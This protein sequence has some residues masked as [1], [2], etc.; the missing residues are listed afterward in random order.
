MLVHEYFT[1]VEYAELSPRALKALVDVYTQFRGNNNGDLQA[2]W[3]LMSKRGW[4]SKDQL[5]KAICE[6]LER[7]WLLVTRQGG[8]QGGRHLPRLYA[9]TW[10][11][12]DYC[13][14]K[15]DVSPN[16]VPAHAWKRPA[17]TTPALH[18]PRTTGQP[19]PQHGSVPAPG[20]ADRPATRV[21]QAPI[22]TCD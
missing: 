10:L 3:S 13:G 15:L 5:G 17:N 22:P 1:S 8:F 20:I 4:T 11:G 6:L 19:A 2:S 21:G 12:I 18:L 14:G 9:V 16:P 7:G